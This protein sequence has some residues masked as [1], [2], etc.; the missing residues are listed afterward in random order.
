VAGARA[1]LGHLFRGDAGSATAA[2]VQLRRCVQAYRL[3]QELP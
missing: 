1:R 2:A 3:G